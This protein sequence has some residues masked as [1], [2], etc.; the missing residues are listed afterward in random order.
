MPFS[1]F[2]IRILDCTNGNPVP[3]SQ[4]FNQGED[5]FFLASNDH[6]TFTDPGFP[7]RKHSPLQE[8]Q[9]QNACKRFRNA[10][11]AFLQSASFAC[12]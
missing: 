11:I 4:M 10:S 1:F 9:S 5:V 7:T 8:R 12:G 3:L 6:V 2:P